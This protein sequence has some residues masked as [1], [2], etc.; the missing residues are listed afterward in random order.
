MTAQNTGGQQYT[1]GYSEEFLKV[2]SRRNAG[3]CAGYLLPL[4]QPGM[5]LLDLGC[6]PGSITVG[7]AEAVSPGEV[8]AVDMEASQ[9]ELARAAATAGNHTNTTFQ[10]GNVM[11]LPYEDNFFDVV[12][13]HA[14]MIHIPDTAGALAEI[15][16]VL[17]PGGIFASRDLITDSCIGYPSSEGL[18]EISETFTGLMRANGGHPDM[19]KE[20]KAY[21]VDNGFT[22]VRCS[23][24]FESFGAPGDMAFYHGLVVDWFFNEAVINRV[25]SLGIATRE[26][27]DYW[28]GEVDRAAE[29]PYAFA[30]FAWGECIGHKA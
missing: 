29:S 6:G 3:D 4:L 1:M 16:R 10:V 24:S 8:H 11:S 12:H 22:D 30:A 2:L 7:L 13:A 15:R 14:V 28:R 9:I 26:K 27:F 19:G 25:T 20:I 5:K 18:L 21:L 17:K 23:A